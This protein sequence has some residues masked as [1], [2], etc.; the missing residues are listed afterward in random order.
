MRTVRARTSSTITATMRMTTRPTIG[1]PLFVDE[2]GRALD[3]HDFDLRARL[4][5]LVGHERARRPLLTAD[6]H[7]AA[8]LVDALQHDRSGPLECGRARAE[9]S[10][11]AP[12]R[13]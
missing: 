1:A 5:R 11:H 9:G 13:A 4:E 8:V 6:A 12:G 3:L 2:R 7:A 10:R